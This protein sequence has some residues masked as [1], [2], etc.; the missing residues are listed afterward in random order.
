MF[1]PTPTKIDRMEL[2]R[3]LH[4][5]HRKLKLLD[6]FNYNTDNQR[7]PFIGQSHWEPRLEGVSNT[8]QTLIQ[9]DST[10]FSTFRFYMAGKDNLTKQE[11]KS[12][13][14]LSKNSNIVIKPADKGSKIVIL[15]KTQYLIEAKR[16]LSNSKHYRPLTHSLQQE[17]QRQMRQIIGELYENNYITDKQM[18]YLFG[19]DT[20]R[21]RQFYLL[22]KI[23]KPPETWTI[24]SEVPCG[25]PIVSDCGSE[26]YRIAEYLDYF[27]NPLSRKHQSFIKDTYEFVTKLKE[28]SVPQETVFF[29]I[30]IDSLYTNIDT[31]LGLRAIKNIFHKYPDLDRPDGALLQLLELSLIRND[32]EFNSNWFLQIHGTAMGKKFAPSYA[33]I[34][35]AEWEQS[36]FPKCTKLP[37][38][39]LRYLDDIFG[40][41]TYSLSDF[42]EFVKIL[43]THHPSITIKHNVQPER[44]E[45]LD[46]E[47]FFVEGSDNLKR[48]ATKVYFKP[49]DTHS[50]LH[51]SSF[52]PKHTYRGL[53]KS[54]LIRF[55]RICT[56]GNHVQEATGILFKA[57]RPRGY[58]KRFLRTIRAEVN[59]MFVTEP[60][61]GRTSNDGCIIPFVT[62]Y[63]QSSMRF[64]SIVKDHFEQTREEVEILQQFRV[65]SAYRRNKNLKDVLVHSGFREKPGG[66]G[67]YFRQVKYIQNKWS[68]LGAPV[69][70]VL[71]LKTTNIVYGIECLQCGK[72]YIG[73][74]RNSLE[75]RLKQHLYYIS[76]ES[77]KTTLYIHFRSHPAAQ[78]RIAGL[79]SNQGWSLKHRQVKERCWIKKLGT[80]NP[81]GLNEKY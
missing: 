27:I 21:P 53:I 23:H 60:I 66:S 80:C 42:M 68:G 31:N 6:H 77:V 47:V 2:R 29:S 10:S 19:P 61:H 8:M 32:F 50:L 51:K 71:Q 62:T 11:R 41:W 33:N 56:Q 55:N 64:N 76:K 54:Q 24:P 18:F 30:D 52:H 26:S 1:I 5:Y 79:E 20:P 37:I 57:L 15:D 28:I 25:R 45:F 58:S 43:N 72:W 34:Y 13:K 46:T 70:E 16:Q 4:T 40:L 38:L 48:L 78:L 22:P 36:V 9:R 67:S 73:E 35:M 63:S 14:S 17:T 3:D 7:I 81:T 49:T 65:I 12:L 44:I 75:A 69:W 39:Y 74:T 59:N